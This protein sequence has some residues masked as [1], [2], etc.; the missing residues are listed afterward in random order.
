[1]KKIIT[2]I[3]TIM[4]VMTLVSCGTERSTTKTVTAGSNTVH[5]TEKVGD[6]EKR[7]DIVYE[8]AQDAWAAVHGK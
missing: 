2:L 8:T 1:M 7:Y 4:M 6:N 5:V 3:L